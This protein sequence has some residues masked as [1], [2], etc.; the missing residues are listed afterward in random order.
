MWCGHDARHHVAWVVVLTILNI[1]SVFF[2]LREPETLAQLIG[3]A[4]SGKLRCGAH[5][6]YISGIVGRK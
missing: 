4:A 6:R 3:K 2:H 5:Y 1:S